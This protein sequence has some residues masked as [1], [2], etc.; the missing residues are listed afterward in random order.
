M[1]KFKKAFMVTALATALTGMSVAAMAE[2][3]EPQLLAQ[4]TAQRVNE[5]GAPAPHM[6]GARHAGMAERMTKRHDAR[7]ARLKDALKIAPE[8][9]AAWSAFVA[10][11][12]PDVRP[13]AREDVRAQREEWR[14]LSTPERLDRMEAAK[15]RRDARMA[16]RNDAIRSLYASLTPEQ[17]K[18][19]DEQATGP[20]PGR[21]VKDHGPGPHG[22]HH[23]QRLLH[24]HDKAPRA[25]PQDCGPGAAPAPA[26]QKG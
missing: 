20:R 1:S 10:R 8:Q 5:A 2:A 16:Q 7:L 3:M 11:T 6:H 13:P 25:M 23:G 26:P 17:Q 4:H 18:V 15:T 14:Q 22:K 9:E 21:H 12:S 19:F 24:R